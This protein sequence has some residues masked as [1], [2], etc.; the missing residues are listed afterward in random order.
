[1]KCKCEVNYC[2]FPLT[3]ERQM[4]PSE[5]ERE[6]AS[7][8]EFKSSIF[9][10]IASV[11]TVTREASNRLLEFQFALIFFT[12]FLLLSLSLSLAMRNCI[13][14]C[15]WCNCYVDCLTFELW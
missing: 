9:H 2:T 3:G 1:M 11:M 4:S 5:K 8:R 7:Q 13:S 12:E 15:Y 14:A 6:R 10:K